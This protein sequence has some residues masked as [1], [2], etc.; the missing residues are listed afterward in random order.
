MRL[1]RRN[2]LLLSAIFVCVCPSPSRAEGQAVTAGPGVGITLPS[3]RSCS[4]GTLVYAH[5]GSFE[6]A[7][8]WTSEAACPFPFGSWGESYDL[9]PGVI[10]CATYWLTRLAE[11]DDLPAD[12]IVWDGGTTGEPGN[13]LFTLPGQYFTGVPIWPQ[14]G[15]YDVAVEFD[16][17]GPFT[18]GFWGDWGCPFALA[19]FL[20]ASDEDGP[21][22]QAWTYENGDIYPP[23]GW[24][25]PSNTPFSECKSLGLGCWFESG[26]IPVRAT[27]W[28]EV[29]GLFRIAQ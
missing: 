12:L 25:H 17:H 21:S 15:Q 6:N 10:R 2:I 26:T 11:H 3:A 13:V 9:G 8:A 7:Y 28:G 27:T 16:I 18:I 24:Q 19:G 22:T 4:G 20:V 5:D 1:C 29:K 14:V 23:G